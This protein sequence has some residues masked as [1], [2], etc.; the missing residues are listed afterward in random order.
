MRAKNNESNY[1]DDYDN[2][3]CSSDEYYSEEELD[4]DQYDRED[5]EGNL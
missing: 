5:Q 3:G 4:Y 1:S 2:G